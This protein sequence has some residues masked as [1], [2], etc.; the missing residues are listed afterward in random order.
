MHI[1]SQWKKVWPRN[2]QWLEYYREI[3]SFSFAT[4]GDNKDQ[5]SH[6]VDVSTG[7]WTNPVIHRFSTWRPRPSLEPDEFLIEEAVRLGTALYLSHV[8]RFFGVVPTLPD[9]LASRLKGLLSE[10]KANWG[11]LWNF[12]LWTLYMAGFGMQDTVEEAWFSEEISKCLL[13]NG[14]TCWDDMIAHAK[15][16][17]WFEQIFSSKDDRMRVSVEHLTKAAEPA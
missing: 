10:D 9:F 11:G 8:W 2:C 1:S 16:I 7:S 14:L 13:S 5:L 15:S 6:P 4:F 12:K 17:L 3:A